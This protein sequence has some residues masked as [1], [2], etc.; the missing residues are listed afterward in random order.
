MLEVADIVV[1]WLA[2]TCLL[3]W[4]I[5]RDEKRLPRWQLDRAWPEATKLSAIVLL[6]P[7][8]L[9]V[10]YTRTRR[11]LWGFLLGMGWFAVLILV[12]SL[13]SFVMELLLGGTA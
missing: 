6:G 11:S 2:T 7:F 5:N 10:H 12:S 8:C 9:P 1:N 13:L 3:F 4:I